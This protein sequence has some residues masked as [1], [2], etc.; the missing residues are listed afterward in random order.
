M[1]SAGRVAAR[2]ALCRD[3]KKELSEIKKTITL[4]DYSECCC[5][6]VAHDT[7]LVKYRTKDMWKYFLISPTE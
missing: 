6:I 5:T 2:S 7:R 1:A 4:A 3:E